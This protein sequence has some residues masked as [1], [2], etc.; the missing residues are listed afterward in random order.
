[1]KWTIALVSMACAAG[2]SFD[3]VWQSQG[4]GYV[5]SVQGPV[6][7]AFEVTSTTCVAGFTARRQMVVTP[8]QKA[9]FKS[10]DQGLFFVRAG[11][12]NDHK[13]L[14]FDGGVSD[15]RIDRL[16]RLPAAC[17]SPTANTP[18]DNFEVFTRT[19]AEHYISFDLK[20]TDWD[21]IVRDNRPTVTARTTPVQLFDILEAM[22]KPFGDL[23]TGIAAPK[24]KRETKEF[25]RPGSD[26]V[27]KGG[28]DRFASRG[29]RMLFAVTDRAYV[30][31]PLRKFCRGKLQFGHIND[32][33]GY[34]RIL[35]FGGYSK[36]EDLK[37]LESA[38]D[39]I[40]SDASVRA[41]VIDV[42][43]AFG[44]SDEL[45]LAISSRLAAVEY[46]AYTKQARF[47]PVDRDK[48]TPGDRILVR[49]SARPGFRGQV[50]E[51]I[52][53]ITM[54]AAE[55]F[56]QALMGRTPHVTRIGENTQ[57]VFSDVLDRRLPNGWSFG[58]PNEVYRTPKG[59]T[60]DGIGIPPDIQVAVYADE[61]VS[62]GRDP[63]IAKALQV[64]S[65]SQ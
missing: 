15:L 13:R 43:L 63:G 38:L 33:T 65:K 47:D 1:M 16:P 9:A 51:L 30:H 24:L 31:G 2:Q 20:H 11:G 60:F 14:H 26:R 4:Y 39:A 41:L 6:L 45:G 52:G 54:S 12:A 56:T 61:D 22:I 19:W 49:P 58:L 17:E 57:G 35:S 40:F 7:K 53:P 44:G 10:K 37:A 46:L 59:T 8:G 32:T 55:T 28:V 62:A 18:I 23:H 64:L 29:R 50:V 42:R 27:I 3:G 21:K 48:W 34:L 5:F 36:H 25:W